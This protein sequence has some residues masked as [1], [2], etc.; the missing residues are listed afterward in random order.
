MK[1]TL[2]TLS[3]SCFLTSSIM[4]ATTINNDLNLQRYNA[5]SH[6][7][8]QSNAGVRD[9]IF[10]LE[11]S[12]NTSVLNIQGLMYLKYENVPNKLVY[13]GILEV[14]KMKAFFDLARALNISKLQ[15]DVEADKLEDLKKHFENLNLK[16]LT[17]VIQKS[18]SFQLNPKEDPKTGVDVSVF[19]EIFERTKQVIINVQSLG[20]AEDFK[21]N[22]IT[23]RL[24]QEIMD[25]VSTQ[26]IISSLKFV[27]SRERE[28]EDDLRSLILNEGTLENLTL[29]NLETTNIVGPFYNVSRAFG[30]SNNPS[31]TPQYIKFLERNHKYQQRFKSSQEKR[32]QAAFSQLKNQYHSIKNRKN[33]DGSPN[34]YGQTFGHE[35]TQMHKH[36]LNGRDI[37]PYLKNLSRQYKVDEGT[38]TQA[39]DEIFIQGKK[40]TQVH[41]NN[42]KL[43]LN[44]QEKN[45]SYNTLRLGYEGSSLHAW[46]SIF[47]KPFF[48][49]LTFLKAH[50]AD[51]GIKVRENTATAE[52]RK[53]YYAKLCLWKQA[54]G[55]I[56][57]IKC[58]KE[59]EVTDI[60]PVPYR[61]NSTILEVFKEKF[62]EFAAD[63]NLSDEELK[64]IDLM[65]ADMEKVDAN[66]SSSLPLEASVRSETEQQVPLMDELDHD[67]LMADQERGRQEI[68]RDRALEMKQMY[69]DFNKG[70]TEITQKSVDDEEEAKLMAQ[71]EAIRQRKITAAPRQ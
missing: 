66:C 45:G 6:S 4:A 11:I 14:K 19:K 43:L 47:S 28:Q 50:V 64:N 5:Q 32:S 7:S 34:L 27:D 46:E 26:S 31:T 58:A 68:I 30:Y 18:E 37:S 21:S 36:I 40:P 9:T 65:D 3:M 60:R 24:V 49:H 56:D 38:L 23:Q 70:R 42:L 2:L 51:L 13:T 16:E 41:L 25:Q 1:K 35:N 61:V 55:F 67:A 15:F 29:T 33:A 71:L 12:S 59:D 54:E 8:V 53:E 10:S 69:S 48:E 39:F 22:F 57:D 17:I 52:E 20:S 62:S 44:H 63:L